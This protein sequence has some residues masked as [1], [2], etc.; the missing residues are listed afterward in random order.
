VGEVYRRSNILLNASMGQVN[1]LCISS[2]L[3]ADHSLRRVGI[4]LLS[5]NR[6]LTL[7]SVDHEQSTNTLVRARSD[8]ELIENERP[9]KRMR[10]ES[11][12]GDHTPEAQ[13]DSAMIVDKTLS[14]EPS[15]L[16]KEYNLENLLPLS[17]SLMGL[18]PAPELP[19]DGFMH[20]TC[21]VDVGIS[22]YIGDGLSEINGI[23]KQR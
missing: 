10:E 17:R 7:M 5:A 8:D 19:P 15:P 11:P 23:I 20:R 2:Q 18:P 14:D 6:L 4:C 16:S 13:A 3:C 12:K 21:E 9:P 1:V 22:Q